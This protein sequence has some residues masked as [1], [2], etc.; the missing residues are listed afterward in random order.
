MKKMIYLIHIDKSRPELH[1]KLKAQAGK[2]N[3][4]GDVHRF[5]GSW[6][7]CGSERATI[8]YLF[9]WLPLELIIRE[10]NEIIVNGN[11]IGGY[12]PVAVHVFRWN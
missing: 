12:N 1:D 2:Y 11:I 8:I 5:I 7:P 10:C 9:I 4:F 3:L 6:F